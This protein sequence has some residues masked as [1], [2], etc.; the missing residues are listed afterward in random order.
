MRGSLCCALLVVVGCST[1]GEHAA[2][3]PPSLFIRKRDL[4]KEFD[5]AAQ[6]AGVKL[7]G[8]NGASH[9]NA[10]GDGKSGRDMTVHFAATSRHA[11]RFLRAL[12]AEILSR[13]R[14]VGALS[15]NEALGR[16]ASAHSWSISYVDGHQ[17]GSITVSCEER[18]DS[19][20]RVRVDWQEGPKPLGTTA[21]H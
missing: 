20:Y 21:A 11:D 15:E 19:R 14:Q 6:Q 3:P 17:H 4:G 5:A 9:L 2:A 1:R 16:D 7:L 10:A 8:C 18:A 12:H 13:A